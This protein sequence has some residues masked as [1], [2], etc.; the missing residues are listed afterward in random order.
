[1]AMPHAHLSKRTRW[2]F[3]WARGHLKSIWLARFALG[4]GIALGIGAAAAPPLG[5]ATKVDGPPRLAPANAHVLAS[6]NT[7]P[8]PASANGRTPASAAGGA[9]TSP[10]ARTPAAPNVG[11]GRKGVAFQVLGSGGPELQ[12]RRASTSYLIWRAGVPRVLVDSGGGSAL[13]FG[14]SG[15]D[16][17]SHWI[18]RWPNPQPTAS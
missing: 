12:D 8:P 5:T 4:F 16:V 1:M 18:P 11:C 9:S 15:R 2:L 13:R 3:E 6:V 10:N 17:A 14:E 7:S